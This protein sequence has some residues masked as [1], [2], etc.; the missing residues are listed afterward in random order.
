MGELGVRGG[1]LGGGLVGLRLGLAGG[2]LVG[3]GLIERL[4][5][6]VEIRLGILQ[7]VR[8]GVRVRLGLVVGGLGGVVLGLRLVKRGLRVGQRVHTVL[9]GLLGV[10][11]LVVGRL[12]LVEVLLGLCEPVGGR[13]LGALRGRRVRLGRIQRGL[14]VRGGLVGRGL[15]GGGVGEPRLGVLRLG[16]RVGQLRLGFGPLGPRLLGGL[17]G[18]I[19]RGVGLRG[20]GVRLVEGGLRGLD[21]GQ[22]VL[23]CL[24]GV[25]QAVVIGVERGLIFVDRVEGAGGNGAMQA[26]ATLPC[27]VVERLAMGDGVGAHVLGVGARDGETG[28]VVVGVDDVGVVAGALRVLHALGLLL[29]VAGLLVGVP[30]VERIVITPREVL[31]DIELFG[32]SLGI[33]IVRPIHVG[34]RLRHKHVG[35]LQRRQS[36]LGTQ[37]VALADVLEAGLHVLQAGRVA[38]LAQFD[39][40][41]VLRGVRV[42]QHLDRVLRAARLEEAERALGDLELRGVRGGLLGIGLLDGGVVGGPRGRL[43]LVRIRG[44]P[45][46]LVQ[47]RLGGISLGV[48]LGL[49]VRGGPTVGLGLRHVGLGGVIGFVGLV[50]VRPRLVV[51]GLRLVHLGLGGIGLLGGLRLGGLR[52]LHVR[53]GRLQL[54]VRGLE[55]L[56]RLFEL[57]LGLL[58][59]G[60]VVR[61]R[62]GLPR[63]VQLRLR[64]VGR[65]LRGIGFLVGG[66]L[67]GLGLVHIGLCV[68]LIFGQLAHI[69]RVGLGL[70][71]RGGLIGLRL[72]V[73]GGLLRLLGLLLVL[74]GLLGGVH[75]GL[76]LALRLLQRGV[77]LIQLG[78]GVVTRLLLRLRGL[79]V[80][81]RHALLGVRHLGLGLILR[82]P[83]LVEARLRVR[84]GLLG[85]GHVGGRRGR[86]RL[87]Q[88]LVGLLVRRHGRLVGERRRRHAC[89]CRDAG[90]RRH[91]DLLDVLVH[92]LPTPFDR[93]QN[94]ARTQ[95]PLAAPRTHPSILLPFGRCVQW[96]V[97]SRNCVRA[98]TRDPCVPAPSLPA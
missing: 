40:R 79:L 42:G 87:L 88:C 33:V 73:L 8:L 18:L 71:I 49:R 3:L 91:H 44:R 28:D 82:L 39:G 48:R 11:G 56:I 77:G 21:L 6:R 31:A 90:G 29:V 80:G 66:G 70:R 81:V 57:L 22:R 30:A 67:V 60:R 98:L 58:D 7:C 15:R 54:A 84:Y 47:L 63:V 75:R 61:V 94:P 24:V 95:P 26:D 1:Q 46:R 2:L 25:H 19:E 52:R 41:E 59:L 51:G 76:V 23:V 36:L 4:V 27:A 10:H 43:G 68:R 55:V 92:I 85:V 45:L 74:L 53:L 12:G 20:G 86:L 14:G 9:R 13:L 89:S 64:L 93:L 32:V 17:G 69:V 65:G 78:G 5:G 62:G 38:I 50:G 37:V 83:G 34:L 16:G 96:R 72:V 97:G 35:H